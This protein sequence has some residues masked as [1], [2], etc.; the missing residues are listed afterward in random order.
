MWD[1]FPYFVIHFFVWSRIKHSAMFTLL[2]VKMS[3]SVQLEFHQLISRFCYSIIFRMKLLVKFA[4]IK[5]DLSFFF[6]LGLNETFYHLVFIILKSSVLS[7][8]KLSEWKEQ[9]WEG[10][11]AK[12]VENHCFKKLSNFITFAVG[13]I[14]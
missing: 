13:L 1:I 2:R 11:E 3:R 7:I 4:E 5:I 12:K 8:M 10:R 9:V 14:L 6:C